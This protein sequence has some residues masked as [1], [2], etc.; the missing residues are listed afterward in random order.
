MHDKATATV[1]TVEVK[2]ARYSFNKSLK[3]WVLQFANVKPKLHE[4]LILV[5]EGLDGMHIFEWGGQNLSKRGKSTDSTGHTIDVT[6]RATKP[7]FNAASDAA[8]GQDEETQQVSRV[9]VL[10]GRHLHRPLRQ[11]GEVRALLRRVA[12]LDALVR[13]GWCLREPRPCRPGRRARARRRERGRHQLRQW[14]IARCQLHDVRL[15]RRQRAHRGQ[16]GARLLEQDGSRL[17]YYSIRSVKLDKFDAL[18]VSFEGANGIHIFRHDPKNGYSTAGKSTDATGGMITMSAP[19]GKG[20]YTVP[21]AVELFLIKQFKS[22]KSTYV[23]FV[24]FDTGDKQG[25]LDAVRK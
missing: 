23:A 8:D 9:R 5:V 19:S 25:L 20:A 11:D 7:D 22:Y 1:R 2:L 17:R 14:C 6:R 12:A 24:A 18:Y 13:E 10:Q 3:C 21:S 16:V 4:D 15:R